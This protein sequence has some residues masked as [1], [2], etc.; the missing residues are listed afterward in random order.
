MSLAYYVYYRVS[1][2]VQARTRVKQIQ[3]VVRDRTGIGGR[4][5]SKRD[6]IA[7]WMEIY[8]GVED[9]GVFEECLAAAVQ[10]AQFAAVLETGSVRHMECFEEPCA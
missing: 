6:D 4:L 5:L 7:T 1:Q 2:P 3:S 9:P 8:E 10:Q